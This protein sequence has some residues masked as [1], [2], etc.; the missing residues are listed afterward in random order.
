MYLSSADFFEII[1]FLKNISGIPSDCQTVWIQIC[2]TIWWPF[3]DLGQNCL[4]RLS[5][6]ATSRQIIKRQIFASTRIILGNRYNDL[7]Y[8]SAFLYSSFT[9]QCIEIRENLYRTV[10]LWMIRSNTGLCLMN[11]GY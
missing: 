1:F 8:M 7:V 5:A 3:F 6:D 2:P 10:L 11:G 9:R 4:Q